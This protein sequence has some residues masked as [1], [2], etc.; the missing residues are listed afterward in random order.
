MFPTLLFLHS[1][2]RWL[3]LLGLIYAIFIAFRGYSKNLNFTKKSDSIRHWTATIAHI[4]LMIGFTL[5]TQ[6]PLVKYYF[7]NPKTF[8]LTGI[9][10]F[11]IIHG[12]LMLVAIIFVTVGSALAKRKVA[13]RD[14]FKTIAIYYSIA[15]LIILIA[16]PWPFSPFSQRPFIRFF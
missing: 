14:K 11:S 9:S 10:F 7:T 2:F 13:D 3:V 12:S 5:Y 8:D 16:I 6:S 4:Q 15:L 1:I